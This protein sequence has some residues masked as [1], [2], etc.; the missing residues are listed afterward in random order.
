MGN[1]GVQCFEVKCFI[2]LF[3]SLRRLDIITFYTIKFIIKFALGFLKT[4]NYCLDNVLMTVYLPDVMY[5]MSIGFLWNFGI[6]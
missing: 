6:Q 2:Y 4:I 3:P 5:L 1:F